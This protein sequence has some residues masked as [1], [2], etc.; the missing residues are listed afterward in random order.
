MGQTPVEV[1][2]IIS[3]NEQWTSEFI[4]IVTDDVRV[5]LNAT[6]SIEAGTKVRFQQ[7]KGL[8]VEGGN[9]FVNGAES[10][11]VTFL[12]NHTSPAQTW[13]WKGISINSIS[14]VDKVLIAYATIQGA[15]VGLEVNSSS[16]VQLQHSCLMNNFWRGISLKN[17]SNCLFSDSHIVNNYVGFELIARNNEHAD[18]NLILNN[19]LSQ[20]TTNILLIIESNGICKN[21]TI[22]GNVIS[23]GIN[24]IWLDNSGASASFRN[25]ILQNAVIQNGG[26]FGYGLYLAMDSTIVSKNIFWENDNA[27][28]FRNASASVL[29]QNTFYQNGSC[30]PIS[31]GSK[32]N[33]IQNNVFVENE[34]HA[35]TINEATGTV[36]LQNNFD[37]NMLDERLVENMT[38]QNLNATANYWG[39]TNEEQI[40]KLIWDQLD[41]A[42]LGEMFYFPFLQALDTTAPVS[43]PF[44]VK[45]QLVGNRIRLSWRPNEESDLS[46]YSVYFSGYQDYQFGQVISGLVDTV[47]YLDNLSLSETIAVTALDQQ[48]DTDKPM[49]LA[50]ESAFAFARTAAYA[51]LDTSICQNQNFFRISNASAPVAYESLR[52]TASGDGYFSEPN[53][54]ST[55]YFPG[56]QD[57]ING[58]TRIQLAVTG[59]EE[60]YTDAFLL[61]YSGNPVAFAGN[62]TIIGIQAPLVL[63]DAQAFNYD[64]VSWESLGD[65]TFDQANVIQPVYQPGDAD[66]A[67]GFV[68]LVM[69][70]SSQCGAYSDTLSVSVL[71]EFSLSGRV[72]FQQQTLEGAVVLAVNLLDNKL[73][74]ASRTRTDSNGAFVFESLFEGNYVVFAVPDTALGLDA[75]ASYYAEREHWENAHLI[76]LNADVFDVDIL[77]RSKAKNM[78]TGTGEIQGVFLLPVEP[79]KALSVFCGDWFNRQPESICSAGLS[80]ISITL[81]N[82]GLNS[83]FDYTLTDVHG[84]FS[85]R[86]L[87]FGFYRLHA[88]VPGYPV[89]IS[90]VFHLNAENNSVNDVEMKVELEK[91]SIYLPEQPI[92]DFDLA[93]VFPNPVRDVL[94]IQLDAGESYTLYIYDL[95]GRVLMEQQIKTDGGEGFP[96]FSLN[97]S[98]L[99]IGAYVGLLRSN[100]R[101]K[102][103]SFV[104]Q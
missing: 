102:R 9:L 30:I 76:A 89:N 2:G 91:I 44:E 40:S 58:S 54:L 61:T 63:Q 49:F 73:R 79:F 48:A 94:T 35:I 95:N 29:S 43:P 16:Y 12:P 81:Y 52:W 56:E 75:V 38:S 14:Q 26:G 57:F 31:S 15:E 69:H 67:L 13:K 34:S 64:L 1:G 17:S 80:N 25:N 19:N 68:Q 6:L 72:W 51:G 39:T 65:G 66:R 33:R 24:G 18:N 62:D 100:T 37:K 101:F 71:N 7:G 8:I 22:Q 36:I 104:K 46:S 77:L 78:P 28:S 92:P 55:I 59:T 70:V 90:P 47:L 87:P 84:R 99:Q 4:Y 27:I 5:S 3:G 50:H 74:S 45:K 21:N 85:F 42:Q 88:E 10:D 96:S 53:D 97:I 41:D 103:F 86:N 93:S 98:A 82:P 32:R 60:T 23:G 11:S 83:S 20:S